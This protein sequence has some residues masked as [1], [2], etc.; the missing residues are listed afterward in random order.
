MDG[1]EIELVDIV[2]NTATLQVYRNGKI[3]GPAFHV[4]IGDR[5]IMKNNT[6][7]P[8]VIDPNNLFEHDGFQEFYK[9]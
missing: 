6:F 2:N 8:A 7:E 9:P 5:F 1:V 4:V 3:H